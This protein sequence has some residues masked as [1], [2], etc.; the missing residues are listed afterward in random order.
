MRKETPRTLF[1]SRFCRSVTWAAGSSTLLG[2][3]RGGRGGPGTVV[4]NIY[5]YVYVCVRVRAGVCVSGKGVGVG[6]RRE[7]ATLLGIRR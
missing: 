2:P 5:M 1:R 3:R 6:E 7:G 4:M